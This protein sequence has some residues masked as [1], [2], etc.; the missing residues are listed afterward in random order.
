MFNFFKKKT[1][2]FYTPV[3]TILIDEIIL[4]YPA[5]KDMGKILKEVKPSSFENGNS[6]K[7][8]PGIVR[9]LK[10]GFIISAWQDIV[11]KTNGD[12]S[13][14]KWENNNCGLNTEVMDSFKGFA[15]G[16]NWQSEKTFFKHFPR[17]NTL[18][19]ILKFD[20]PWFIKL[21]P[22]Y[23]ALFV[24]AFYDNEERFTVIPGILET[25]YY[26]VINIQVYWHRLNSTEIIKAGTP[27]IKIIPFKNDEW[28]SKVRLASYE[29]AIDYRRVRYFSH[30]MF[31][32][33][34]KRFQNMIDNFKKKKHFYKIF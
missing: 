29:E 19:S 4:P 34:M 23:S 25:D 24:P 33:S 5:K 9:Y 11:I 1:V 27:L 18:K 31:N 8:C 13:T 3:E 21:P 17:E 22:G 10:T 15:M 32:G 12:G 2:E 7:N 26:G 28:D 16:V 14:Y 20:T 30:Y 6:I